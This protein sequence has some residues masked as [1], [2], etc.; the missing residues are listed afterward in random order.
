MA[1]LTQICPQCGY[2]NTAQEIACA[3]CTYFLGTVSPSKENLPVTM[4]SVPR[5]RSTDTKRTFIASILFL[6][7]VGYS[8]RSVDEQVHCKRHFNMLIGKS[9]ANIEEADRVL[10]DTG[11]GAALCF[12]E[13][14]EEALNAA[15]RLLRVILGLKKTNAPYYQL[16]LGINLGP[17]KIMQDFN[18]QRNVIGDGINVAQR[19]VSFAKPNQLLVSRS[20]YEL[21]VSLNQSRKVLFK[22]QGIHLDKHEREHEVYEFLTSSSLQASQSTTKPV[23][24]PANVSGADDE[25]PVNVLAESSQYTVPV[26]YLEAISSFQIYPITKGAVLGQA[27][28]G[29][30]ADIQISDL[31]GCQYIHRQHCR[32]EWLNQR[33]YVMPIDQRTL[34][35]D[36]TNPTALNGYRLAAGKLHPLQNGDKLE[37]SGV[38]FYVQIVK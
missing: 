23:I 29:G 21:V 31:E 5:E 3:V 24:E 19:I 9:I 11:D 4:H 25:L 1:V 20:F 32:F 37:L 27:H 22:Y 38:G 2:R 16:Y 17:I 7:I 36:F 15:I 6:D 33:W 30:G 26:L 28:V 8:K 34:G 35:R 12:L 14:P 18:S 13:N 10:L